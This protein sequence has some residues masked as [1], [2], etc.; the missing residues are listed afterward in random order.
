MCMFTFL[1]LGLLALACG[2]LLIFIYSFIFH[3]L[4]ATVDCIVPSP[5]VE[6]I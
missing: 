3:C 2:L 5:K 1:T 6:E 4:I